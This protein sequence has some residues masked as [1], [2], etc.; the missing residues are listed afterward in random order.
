MSTTPKKAVSPSPDPVLSKVWITKYALTKGVYTVENVKQSGSMIR[1][2]GVYYA[3]KPHWHETED[4]ARVQVQKMVD[5]E[6][7]SIEKKRAKLETL[8]VRVQGPV[9]SK[10]WGT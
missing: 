2:G 10:P 5:A 8:R 9:P 4:E 6:L 3:H 1:I 7:K